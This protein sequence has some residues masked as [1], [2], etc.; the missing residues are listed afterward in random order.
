[1]AQNDIRPLLNWRNRDLTRSVTDERVYPQERPTLDPVYGDYVNTEEPIGPPTIGPLSI[2]PTDYLTP[3]G[4]A[5][6]GGSLVAGL[7]GLAAG[8]SLPLIVG[9]ANTTT[10]KTLR[11]MLAQ[12]ATQDRSALSASER[13]LMETFGEK[14]VREAAAA[15][16]VS[17]AEAAALASPGSA[18][19]QNAIVSGNAGKMAPDYFRKL[20]DAQG[21]AEVLRQAQAGVHLKRQAGGGYVG[22]PRDV[23]SPQ[24]LG[25]MRSRFDNQF[26]GGAN[27]IAASD[28]PDRVGT[29]YDRAKQGQ[30]MSN[31][32]YQ[33]PRTLE[34]HSVYSAGVAPEM[35]LG[36]ALNHANSRA[37]G[38]PQMAYRS[39]GANKLD[40]AVAAGVPAQL[41]YKIG[42]Y[43][44]K[45]DPRL[46]NGGLFGVNDFRASQSWG[47]TD[48]SGKPWKAG[49]SDTMHPPMDAETALAVKRAND[50]GIGGRTDWRGPHLQEVPWVLGKAEDMYSR[51]YKARYSPENNGGSVI[52]GIKAAVR[53]ANQ[54]TADYFPKHTMSSTWEAVP[55]VSTGHVPSI[56]TATPEQKLAY[57]QTGRWDIPTDTLATESG[58]VVGAGNRDAIYSAMGLRQL[59]S[60]ESI[61]A[62]RNSQG[63]MEN[64]PVTMAR[65]LVDMDKGNLSQFVNPRTLKGVDSAENFRG[66]IDAQEAYGANLPVTNPSA[67]GKSSLLI[68][69]ANRDPFGGQQ[70]NP[71]QA[72]RLS[73]LLQGS[74]FEPMATSRGVLLRNTA[75]EPSAAQVRALAKGMGNDITDILPGKLTPAAYG[76][77]SDFNR[78][79][80]VFGTAHGSYDDAGN[81]VPF[82]PGSGQ[83]TAQVLNKFAAQPQDI[84]ANISESDAIRRVIR[85][86]TARDAGLEGARPDIQNTRKFF[87]E[88]DW[89]KIVAQIRAGMT[90]AAALAASGYSLSGMAEES[91]R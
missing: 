75:D 80:G 18:P 8:S 45:N 76:S 26:D 41:A 48:P 10:K 20:Q 67:G 86:K 4:L 1:M 53:D 37:L 91:P 51:G 69:T 27:A 34:Q 28:T 88:A 52:E 54:T 3:G 5:K 35:E 39:A 21:E 13:K 11:E 81:F 31:E 9:M 65:P 73:T 14:F 23:Q 58:N 29:W 24:S 71:D 38:D 66:L 49:A 6:M 77:P 12:M 63:V 62:Y 89:A 64:N 19:G 57:Q 55:G 7:K 46:P 44:K 87:S 15:K 32:T 16:R 84:A 43:G 78:G 70:W 22:L 42:E 83:A 30:A 74:G 40:E 2:D 68:D 33:L 59:P 60:V 36:F 47:Y 82:T 50:M 72:N 25:A 85:Q 79:S 17:R 90:P 61:G 56:L